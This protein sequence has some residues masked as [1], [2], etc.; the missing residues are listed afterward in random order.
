MPNGAKCWCFTINNPTEED[1]CAEDILRGEDRSVRST[2]VRTQ[3][4]N[5][6]AKY[7]IWQFESGENGTLH[8]QGYVEWDRKHTFEHVIRLFRGRGHWEIRRDTAEKAR[9]YCKKLDGQVAG[10]WEIGVWEDHSFA[11]KRTDLIEIKRKLDEGTSIKTIAEEHFTDYIRYYKAFENYQ[12]LKQQKRD[13]KSHVTVV[14]GQTGVGKST[15]LREQAPEAYWV[16]PPKGAEGIWWDGYQGEKDVIFDD[17]VDWV[18][19]RTLLRWMDSFPLRVQFKGGSKEFAPER[20]WFSSNKH[21]RNWF[22]NEDY[23]PLA[24]RIDVL[25]E[26]RGR[27]WGLPGAELSGEHSGELGR[28]GQ[29]LEDPK[30]RNV[31]ATRYQGQTE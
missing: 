28:M 31:I 23:E 25:Y 27:S 18:P 16:S 5:C 1:A 29:L 24:R 3:A 12:D 17:F 22:E 21:P 15:W 2:N 30:E 8:I 14:V 9:N 19:Y 10:P 11:G 20:I 26:F 4:Q 13:A 7:A 6:R